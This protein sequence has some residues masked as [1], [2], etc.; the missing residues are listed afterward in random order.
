VATIAA[1]TALRDQIIAVFQAS[2]S[3]LGSAK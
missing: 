1:V 2:A 3:T